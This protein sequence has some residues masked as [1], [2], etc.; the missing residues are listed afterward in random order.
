MVEA[1]LRAAPTGKLGIGYSL[2]Q[3]P[4]FLFSGILSAATLFPALITPGP[5]ARDHPV[6]S[7]HELI[8]GQRPILYFG[9]HYSM[10]AHFTLSRKASPSVLRAG[11][12][13]HGPTL[14]CWKPKASVL[15][16]DIT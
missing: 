8:F 3:S 15:R 14:L 2:K 9:R 16:A 6:F 13:L 12:T 11:I 5:E 1:T 4:F 7:A 10:S